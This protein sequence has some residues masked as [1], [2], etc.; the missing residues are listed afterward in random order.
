MVELASLDQES[1]VKRKTSSRAVLIFADSLKLDLV[2]RRWP[3]HFQRLLRLPISSWKRLPKKADLH[4]FTRSATSCALEHASELEI[5][6]QPQRPFAKNLEAAL[7]EL[8]ERGYEDTV[9]IG[10]DCPELEEDDLLEAFDQLGSCRLVVGPDHKGG[11]YLIGL[12]LKER[13][14]LSNIVWRQ[15]TDCRQLIDKAGTEATWLLPVKQDLDSLADILLLSR[16]GTRL[17][18][19][20]TLLLATLTQL[21][22]EKTIPVFED[23]VERTSWQLPPPAPPSV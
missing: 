21:F 2:R 8:Y 16:L 12:H 14:L 15:D 1:M 19:L 18:E 9:I 7:Q 5:H 3:E 6:L 10:R 17:K 22:C 20:A 13:Q 11:V 4:L 23:Q